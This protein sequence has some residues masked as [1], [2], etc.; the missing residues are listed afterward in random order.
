MQSTCDVAVRF[1]FEMH[2]EEWINVIMGC[3]LVVDGWLMEKSETSSNRQQ[4]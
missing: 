1:E 4:G 3:W 2:G